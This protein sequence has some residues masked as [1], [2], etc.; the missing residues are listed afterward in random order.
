[1]HPFA[2]LAR[3]VREWREWRRVRHEPDLVRRWRTLIPPRVVWYASQGKGR[4]N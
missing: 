2:Q 1:M 3:V 4:V